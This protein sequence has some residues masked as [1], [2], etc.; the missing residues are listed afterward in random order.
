MSGSIASET[1]GGLEARDSKTGGARK[2]KFQPSIRKASFQM[3]EDR[4]VIVD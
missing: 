1:Q 4:F 2:V 3:K